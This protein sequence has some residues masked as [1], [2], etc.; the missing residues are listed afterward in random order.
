LQKKLQLPGFIESGVSAL[1]R[2]AT[3]KPMK[4]G[5]GNNYSLATQWWKED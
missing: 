1:I 4:A 5:D 3:L 2:Q